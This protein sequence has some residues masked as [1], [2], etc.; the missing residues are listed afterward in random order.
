MKE[1]HLNFLDHFYLYNLLQ[2]KQRKIS[3][4][5]ATNYIL[6][7]KALNYYIIP[8]LNKRK[9]MSP[10]FAATMLNPIPLLDLCS[11]II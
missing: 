9:N 4:H 2:Q 3:L 7:Y 6:N 8:Q 5:T 10:T 11:L 1:Y